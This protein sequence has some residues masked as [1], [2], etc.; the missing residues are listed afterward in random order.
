[1]LLPTD[2]RCE[3]TVS[4]VPHVAPL[5]LLR[6]MVVAMGAWAPVDGHVETVTCPA[7]HSG[8]EAFRDRQDRQDESVW[9]AIPELVS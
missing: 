1:M 8:L 7:D 3:V 6:A 4:V 9:V 2:L 5:P